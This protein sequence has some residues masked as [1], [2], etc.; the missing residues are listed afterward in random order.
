MI[1]FDKSLPGKKYIE[2]VNIQMDNG[3]TIYDNI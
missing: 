3:E 2:R 1:K